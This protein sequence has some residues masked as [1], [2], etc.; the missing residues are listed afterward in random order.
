MNSGTAPRARLTL[1]LP[2]RGSAAL[3]CRRS[4]GSQIHRLG[5]SLRT[6]AVKPQTRMLI[7][8]SA[9]VTCGVLAR[10]A[11]VAQGDHAAPRPGRGPAR[12][13]SAAA[14][15]ATASAARCRRSARRSPAGWLQRRARG[16]R[17]RGEGGRIGGSAA[18]AR[19]ARGRR[20]RPGPPRRTRTPV[21]RRRAPAA[22]TR[23]GPRRSPGPAAARAGRSP[24]RR[25]RAAPAGPAGG[26][27][28][29]PAGRTGHRPARARR[30]GSPRRRPATPPA[31]SA[32]SCAVTAGGSG[33][34]PIRCSAARAATRS[35]RSSASA[36]A[37]AL[38]AVDQ[39]SKAER[40]QRRR[41][42][43]P[44]VPPRCAIRGGIPSSAALVAAAATVS[45]AAAGREPAGDARQRDEGRTPGRRRDSPACR[46]IAIT[47]PINRETAAG[48]RTRA[49]GGPSGSGDLRAGGKRCGDVHGPENRP[50]LPCAPFAGRP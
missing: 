4:S 27:R 43:R 37:S 30:C 40:Q 25:P 6:K 36:T 47:K 38:R 41:I 22:G 45:A 29:R 12:M 17:G 20:R 13:M 44:S 7:A 11:A 48:A 35:S 49:H 23:R 42:A 3:R 19:R 39:A 15:A 2:N 8:I 34:A 14:A 33:S 46:A 28:P 50:L 26:R 1:S 21:A 5:T 32:I 24:G 10:K 16:D 18:A 31:R 9:R